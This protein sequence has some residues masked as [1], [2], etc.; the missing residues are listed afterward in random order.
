MLCKRYT[1]E[2]IEE[3]WRHTGEPLRSFQFVSYR[4]RSVLVVVGFFCDTYHG[5]ET[6]RL[7]SHWIGIVKMDGW[8]C[9]KPSKQADRVTE[10]IEWEG[11]TQRTTLRTHYYHAGRGFDEIW[12]RLQT[13][14]F[15]IFTSCSIL[16]PWV[17][18]RDF[19][20]LRCRRMFRH[21]GFWSLKL[22]SQKDE[23]FECLNLIISWRLSNSIICAMMM[24][25]K[26]ISM[27]TAP[28]LRV[29]ITFYRPPSP[30]STRVYMDVRK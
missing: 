3:K 26:L 10:W 18:V 12:I 4:D 7:D 27:E 28:I 30:G 19:L 8:F 29:T 15:N 22:L 23:E 17:C 21:F 14:A 13:L 16:C 9:H 6:V 1:A 11:A 24:L 2:S 20:V 25:S 5:G